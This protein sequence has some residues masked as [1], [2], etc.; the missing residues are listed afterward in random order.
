M[1]SVDE[2]KERIKYL[3]NVNQE[4]EQEFDT[5]TEKL[6]LNLR[7]I[8]KIYNSLKSCIF[9]LDH[10]GNIVESNDAAKSAVGEDRQNIL[11]CLNNSNQSEYFAYRLIDNE[12]HQEDF[13]LR[14]FNIWKDEYVSYA[15]TLTF[16]FG[17]N[18]KDTKLLLVAVD[19]SKIK[20][21]EMKRAQLQN[22]LMQRS[23]KEGMAENAVSILHNIGNVL[24]GITGIIQTPKTL[25]NY[26]QSYKSLDLLVKNLNKMGE[27]GDLKNFLLDDTKSSKMIQLINSCLHDFENFEIEFKESLDQ[28]NTKVQHISSIIAVQQQYANLKEGIKTKVKFGQLIDDCLLINEAKILKPHIHLVREWTSGIELHIEKNGFI[29][30]LSNALVNSIE[31]IEEKMRRAGKTKGRGEITIKTYIVDDRIFIEIKD[32]GLGFSDETREKLFQFGFSTKQR[33]S[34]FGL[35]NCFNFIKA[36]GGE[37]ELQSPGE[38]EGAS[39]IISFQKDH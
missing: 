1:E 11:E 4:L 21:E 19:M 29:Q 30:V 36:Q 33:S 15:C 26:Q 39:F 28:I 7:N 6:Y 31:S 34:G 35:H 3:E 14:L 22:Q 17:D 8:Q 23:Y 9:L 20:E 25:H 38:G 27:R 32:N 16:L 12:T 2:L 18:E 13:E 10:A 37:V 5:Q 24:T